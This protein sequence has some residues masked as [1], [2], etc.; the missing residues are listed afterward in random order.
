MSTINVDNIAEYTSSGK[1]NATHDIKMASGK[2]ILNSDGYSTG[3]MVKLASTTAS[4]DAAIIFDN[5]VDHD[6]YI[7]YKL[8]FKDIKPG[9]DNVSFNVKFR[10]GGASGS[11]LTGNYGKFGYYGYGDSS[12]G[13]FISNSTATDYS[14]VTGSVGS[15]ATE[16]VS[17]S[18]EFFA[19]SATGTP[20]INTIVN[21]KAD[22][23]QRQVTNFTAMMEDAA[24]ATGVAFYFSSGNVASGL[25]NVYGVTK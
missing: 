4:D 7:S 18:A 16:T 3:A 21:Y 2:S 12:T 9:T 1:I 20:A 17:G 19:N 23:G 5:F 13:T 24:T 15:G 6:T 8:Y 10:T 22:G 11:Y 25:I 14:T